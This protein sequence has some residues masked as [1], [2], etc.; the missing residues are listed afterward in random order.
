MRKNKLLIFG[1]V[2]LIIGAAT[3]FTGM[4]LNGF[5]FDNFSQY[6]YVDKSEEYVVTTDTLNIT[7]QDANSFTSILTTS[8]VTFVKSKDEKIKIDYSLVN[9]YEG[10]KPIFEIKNG[11]NFNINLLP[12]S[13]SLTNVSFNYNDTKIIISIPE[14]IKHVNIN[15]CNMTA[16]FTNITLSSVNTTVK[17]LY[18]KAIDSTINELTIDS[19][20]GKVTIKNCNITDSIIN[21]SNLD[22]DIDNSKIET[23]K[24]ESNNSEYDIQDSVI[25]KIDIKTN[26]ATIDLE[27]V[28]VQTLQVFAN[29][30]T[31]DLELAGNS[32]D[33]LVNV[34]F[35]VGKS[36]LPNSNVG[37]RIINITSNTGTLKAK[38]YN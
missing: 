26:N 35:D 3:T 11:E 5:K 2:L 32:T 16:K 20:N 33:Y 14:T 7:E 18:F 22:L 19:T 28:D 8:T 27:K 34:K 17:N 31:F 4:A 37:D 29:N 23:M 15:T 38:F 13:R 21:M 1:F 12:T 36:N 10:T 30:A 25:N 24:S 9:Y 6:T